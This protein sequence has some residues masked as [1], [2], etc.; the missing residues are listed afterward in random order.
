MVQK[1]EYFGAYVLR[2][3]NYKIPTGE[4]GLFGG[5]KTN[6][7]PTWVTDLPS[8]EHLPIEQFLNRMGDDGWEMAGVAQAWSAAGSANASADALFPVHVLYFKHPKS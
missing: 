1:W 4:K 6:T 5:E 3:A 8:G 2:D 7:V